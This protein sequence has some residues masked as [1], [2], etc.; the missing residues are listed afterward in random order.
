[1]DQRNF[2]NY[3]CLNKIIA[4]IS[5]LS[6][7]Q[8]KFFKKSLMNRT[9]NELQLMESLSEMIL[10][11]AGNSFETLCKDYLWT[12]DEI[13][14]ESIF[15]IR[16]GRYRFSNLNEVD[17]FVYS[18]PNYMSK[19]LNG[20]LLSQVLWP[21]QLKSIDVLMNEYMP[22][23]SEQFRHIEIGPGHGLLL[24]L[25]ASS[26][27]CIEAQGWDISESSLKHTEH[28]IKILGTSGKIKLI[29][30]N[31][32]EA[33][34]CEQFKFDS[35]VISEVLE[36]IESPSNV[37][38]AI[39]KNIKSNGKIFIN[40]PINSPALDHIYLLKSIQECE[41]L[42]RESGFTLLRSIQVPMADY[43]FEKAMKLNA[44]V[45]C[46]MIAQKR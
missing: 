22:M 38:R 34:L 46:I 41:S 33:D 20:L 21:N 26:K 44:T 3:D 12:C 35:V 23:F 9:L 5:S 19:Y 8:Q 16:E 18:N 11:I 2:S 14:N 39:F 45:S 6:L 36:H 10:K 4:Y 30:S 32:E 25:V 7:T 27:Y 24:N 40:V 29:K 17:Q 13:T 31:I 15:F 43:T 42:V 37:L 28:C 1:M